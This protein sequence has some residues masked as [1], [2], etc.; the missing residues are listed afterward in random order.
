MN[1]NTKLS[2]RAKARRSKALFRLAY[3]GFAAII[4][5]VI[6][7][8]SLNVRSILKE[9]EGN[10]PEYQAQA[11]LEQLSNDAK[12]PDMFWAK[13]S[14]DEVTK[15]VYE[16]DLDVKGDYLKLYT[17]SELNYAIKNGTYPE[18]E[19]H[20]VIRKEKRELAE[21]TLKATSE[22]IT[23]LAVFSSREWKIEA[24]EP[25]FEAQEYTL[26]VPDD[27]SVSANGVSVSKEDGKADENG[28]ISYT[29]SGVY[30]EPTFDISDASGNDVS[31]VIKNFKVMPEYY[32]YTLT[33][34]YTLKV[35][36]N[37]V[38]DKG[39]ERQNGFVLHEI[40]S[41]QKPEVTISDL[42]GNIVSYEGKSFDIT[43]MTITAPDTFKVSVSDKDI[44][45][46][47]ITVTDNPEYQV[48]GDLVE[49]LPKK[50]EYN[51]A[52][53]EKDANVS[54]LDSS[55]HA[56]ELNANEKFHNLMNVEILDTVPSEVEAEINV[57]KVAQNWSLYMSNDFT[58]ANI[59][60]LMLPN[61]YQYKAA[62]DYSTSID[63][64][65]FSYHTLL[66]PAFTD[67][68]VQN[69]VWITDDCF[70]VEVSF[71]K[72]MHLTS[73]GQL[74]DDPMNDR[75]YYV[76]SN[77]KWLLAAMKEVVNDGEQ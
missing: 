64:T 57:L 68:K 70:S 6:I 60:K 30:T 3:I 26:Q 76:K 54:V 75:F 17:D 49:N 43:Y 77:G 7:I 25:I 36:V 40:R 11:A 47:A 22:T 38:E 19:L 1:T 32:D 10:Q 34:P 46:D 35:T 39:V 63:R 67:N 62:R 61:S 27:F 18:D 55:G 16:Q 23:K 20:Y 21:V 33:I 12:T 8:C 72:H 13:Y 58:F 31:Y 74:R 28:L 45:S 29:I 9:Y 71:V 51:I 42:F 56:V 15:S 44:P 53:L 73:T 41:L 5:I 48:L 24:I 2:A 69:F 52:I 66:D 59:S 50:A 14:L 65:L 37:G 4:L